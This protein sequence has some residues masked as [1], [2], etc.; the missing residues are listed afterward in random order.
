MSESIRG[1]MKQYQAFCE[2]APYYVVFEE[3]SPTGAMTKQRVQ[4]GFDVD[5]YGLKK[6]MAPGPLADYAFGCA[7]LGEVA[8]RAT[9]ATDDSCSVE[10]IPF[11]STV[12]LDPRR[13]LQPEGMIRIRITHGRGVA[14][15]AGEPEEKALHA[16]LAQL[17][18]LGV[19][20][21]SGSS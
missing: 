20:S 9:G 18:D 15:P 5:V 10:V 6:G 11:P 14:Q 3:R 12:V 4:A 17:R 1:F 13:Q 7:A 8:Q 16:V 21:G 2:T 19:S